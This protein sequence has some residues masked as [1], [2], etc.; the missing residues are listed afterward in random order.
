MEPREIQIY[1]YAGPP[2]VVVT[3]LNP[4]EDTIQWL[5]YLVA[6]D[7]LMDLLRKVHNLRGEKAKVRV[8]RIV[9][10][11][12]DAVLLLEQALASREE[13]SFL[14]A[15][16]A[17]LNLARVYVLLDSGP[18]KLD[19]SR[20]HGAKYEE[21]DAGFDPMND[22]ILFDKSG[23]LPFFYETLT[24]Q[25]LVTQAR[26]RAI[27]MRNV[28]PYV[29]GIDVEYSLSLGKAHQ[30]PAFRVSCVGDKKAGYR[31]YVEPLRSGR[32]QI[33][34]NNVPAFAAFKKDEKNACFLSPTFR[35]TDSRLNEDLRKQIACH[36]LYY[37]ET[38]QPP[39]ACTGPGVPPFPE[40]F[41]ILLLFFHMS[42]VVRYNPVFLF[43]LRESKY[44]PMLAAARRHSLLRFLILFWS[45]VHKKQFLLNPTA[46]VTQED[47]SRLDKR[48]AGL[49]GPR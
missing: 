25:S 11:I 9:P 14:P 19:R 47:V 28:Y 35:S 40:E 43:Q 12:K 1:R 23:S 22:Q 2:E 17:M 8:K 3:Q 46:A 13:V 44:W 27:K 48:V 30:M 6:K 7:Y 10:H 21:R 38:G 26:C 32:T 45:H 18:Q 42:N 15:Y 33:D 29:S 41:P 31:L 4:F 36:L 24:G 39:A 20:T 16:Y 49:E 37:S 5:G 34:I